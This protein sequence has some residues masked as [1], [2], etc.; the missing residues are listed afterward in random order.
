MNKI[1]YFVKKAQFCVAKSDI[2][3]IVKMSKN[4]ANKQIPRKHI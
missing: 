1:E 2:C 3:D 4:I